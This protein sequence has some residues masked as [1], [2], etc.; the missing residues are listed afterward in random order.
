MMTS[1]T[2]RQF[3]DNARKR[4]FPHPDYLLESARS[5]REE[6][7]EEGVYHLIGVFGGWIL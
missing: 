6:F 2:G 5:A 1:S 7:L 3:V 4:L